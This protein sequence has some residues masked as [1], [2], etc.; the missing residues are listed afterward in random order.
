M[1][2]SRAIETFVELE[3]VVIDILFNQITFYNL[4]NQRTY[5]DTILFFKH[6][7]HHRWPVFSLLLSVT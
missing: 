3:T 5:I 4:P 1:M 2:V 6:N 7:Y